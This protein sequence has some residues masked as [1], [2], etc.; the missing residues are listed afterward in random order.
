[1]RWTDTVRSRPKA[2]ATPAALRR[3]G[4]V[5]AVASSV[6]AA[7]LAWRGQR[8]ALPVAGLAL[9]L[10]LLALVRPAVLGP[11]ERAWM[12][13]A[14]FM[15]VVV[16]TVLLTLTFI[17]VILPVGLVRRALLRDPFGLRLDRSRPSYWTP[18]E[19]DGPGTRPD[20]PY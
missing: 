3:F 12:A 4:F 11:I 5:M 17:V 13:L 8:F 2:A 16:T 14:E 7:L 9:A 20:K 15:G 19:P 18:V 1:M 10:A 6:L